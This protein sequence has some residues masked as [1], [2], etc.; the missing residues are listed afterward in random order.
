M[1]FHKSLCIAILVSLSAGGAVFF[2]SP[3]PSSAGGGYGLITLDAACPDRFVG[4]TLAGMGA[5]PYI[6]ESTQW[7]FIDDFGELARIPLDQYENRLE[8]FDP[9]NDGYAEKLRSFFVRE[10][11]RRFFIPLAGKPPEFSRTLGERLR[12]ALGDIPFS[13]ELIGSPAPRR[14]GFPGER[15]LFALAAAGFLFFSG[16]PLAAA[17]LLPL[18][19][20]LCLTCPGGFALA[21]ALAALFFAQGGLLREWFTARRYGRRGFI[22]RQGGRGGFFAA[23]PALA[24]LWGLYGLI[25][26]T[27]GAALPPALAGGAAFCLV[28]PAAF[29]VESNRGTSAGHIRFLPV[30]IRDPG[31]RRFFPSP[32][33]LPFG[34]AA[35]IALFLP[36]FFSAP[37]SPLSLASEEEGYAQMRGD[38]QN[39]AAF[40]SSFSRRPLGGSGEGGYFRYRLDGD[41]LIAAGSESP[42]GGEA[43][44]G[45]SG[46]EPP[47][48]PLEELLVFLETYE[49]PVVFSYTGRGI[50]SALAG[51]VLGLPA[52]FR[53]GRRR[54]KGKRIYLYSDKRIAA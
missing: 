45:F 15:V 25:A 46:E 1:T 27:G 35:L 21:A 39:H 41:G 9:R 40:Q 28:L 38:Y 32:G 51:F 12:A 54:R 3:P 36:G 22:S 19:A 13:I 10:G 23:V 34:L 24:A 16:S 4:E 14:G 47:P 50:F 5:E 49:K 43:G 17:F 20:A 42:Y 18:L 2:L 7:V 48:F 53:A 29:W 37:P 52:L 6:S 30:P 26:W 44:G 8:P 31:I 11:K 33:V